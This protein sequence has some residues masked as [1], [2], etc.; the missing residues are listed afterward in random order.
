MLV[1]WDS[2]WMMG[3]SP[4]SETKCSLV[5]GIPDDE[6]SRRS[7]S[8]RGRTLPNVH[9]GFWPALLGRLAPS[10]PW[11][12]SA[13]NR[14]EYQ[15]S[16]WGVERGRCVRLTDSP[17]CVSRLSRYVENVSQPYGPPRSATGIALL[18][19]LLL[20]Y[21]NNFTFRAVR[22]MICLCE[23]GAAC[24]LLLVLFVLCFT[25]WGGT[26]NME[27]VLPNSTALQSWSWIRQWGGS[28][29]YSLS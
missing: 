10:W 12:D 8:F 13:S 15:E 9:S 6:W 22:G 11:V 5:L 16:F 28:D 21:G 24:R 23:V 1:Q 19:F 17:H 26:W 20:F 25:L 7:T 2:F 18:S 27:G 14:N 4:V 3:T 29:V